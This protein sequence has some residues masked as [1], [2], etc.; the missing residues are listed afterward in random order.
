[1]QDDERIYS[2]I[3]LSQGLIS[4]VVVG[5]IPVHTIQPR[6]KY[7]AHDFVKSSA[8]GKVTFHAVNIQAKDK[9][10]V[11]FGP[12]DYAQLEHNKKQEHLTFEM[13]FFVL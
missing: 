4:K 5:F 1:M 7:D 3:N 13:K 10:W 12:W 9:D 11:S 6:P 2:E 8:N